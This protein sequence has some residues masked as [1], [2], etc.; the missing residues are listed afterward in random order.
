MISHDPEELLPHIMT[1]SEGGKTPIHISSA[2]PKTEF[3]EE[4]DIFTLPLP[5]QSCIQEK[6]KQGQKR[7]N[8]IYFKYHGFI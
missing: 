5:S 3:D 1:S 6:G 2:P 4:F 7:E 8:A